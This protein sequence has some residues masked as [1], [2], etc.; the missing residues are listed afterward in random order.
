MLPHEDPASH[1]K[2]TPKHDMCRNRST[3]IRHHS[4]FLVLAKAGDVG[5][6][7]KLEKLANGTFP[8]QVCKQKVA[9]LMI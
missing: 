5:K 3:R 1:T 7:I 8:T 6:N 2:I 9:V 4:F